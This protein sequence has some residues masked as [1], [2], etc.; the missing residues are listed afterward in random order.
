VE[1]HLI[2]KMKVDLLLFEG[3]KSVNKKIEID[4]L[5]ERLN[6]KR[7]YL[8]SLQIKDIIDYFDA[9]VE[10][11]KRSKILKKAFFSRNLIEF[12]S[13]ENLE[14]NLKLALRG[15]FEVLDNFCDL[16]DKK[17]LFH[18]QPRGLVI[19][20]L[21]GNVPILG[22][23][24]I[25]TCAVTKNVCIAKASSK[26]YKDLIYLLQTLSQVKTKKIVGRK[27]LETI[28]V[29]LVD[30][31]DTEVHTQLSM[32]ADVRIAWGG[33][34]SI[35]TIEGLTKNTYCEDIIF[36]PKYSYAVI[37][38]ASVRKNMSGV[39]RNL[40]IDVSVFDQYACSSPHTVFV[41]E[42]K[43]VQAVDF[44]R[45]LAKQLDMVNSKVLPKG[46]IDP[47]KAY[48]IISLRNEYAITGKVFC[49]KGTEWTVI[50]TKEKG[51]ARGSFSR[52]IVVKPLAK[53]TELGNFNDR[54]KQ[55]LGVA[56]SVKNKLSL[57]DSVTF[58]GV[59]R[60]PDLGYMTF[61]ES[62]WDGMFVFDRLVRWITIY[63]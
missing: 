23:F 24:S 46:K 29:I 5:V 40:A 25:L 14:S 22:L 58:K 44:A 59:D 7:E 33:E 56:M 1:I 26:G 41:E 30:R 45:E 31:A 34:E 9:V 57:L 11:W 47:G 8:H 38:A 49:S 4:D 48:E 12:F 43:N 27:I 36:G 54:K 19:Q 37:D 13:R 10:F 21:A 50:Y 52:V 28:S 62:P 17:F 20:W 42:N 35:S 16:G 39:A 53:L 51:L 55:T 3:K 32:N 15:N 61:Y 63:K 6:E 2:L 18:A 60:C